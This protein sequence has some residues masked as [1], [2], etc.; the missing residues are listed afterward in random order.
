V[1]LWRTL[2]SHGFSDLPPLRLDE[3]ARTLELTVPMP[4]GRP[5]RVR[6]GGGRRGRAAVEV[7]GGGALSAA[8]RAAVTAA[9]TH[10]L[11]LDQDLSGFYAM[12]DQ[13]PDL[14]WVTAGAGRML[15]SP[16]VFE[17]VVKTICTT[18]CTWALTTVM[19]TALVTQLGEPAAGHAR[20]PRSNAF[21]SPAAMAA[22][23]ECVYRDTIRAGYRAPN[24]LRLATMVA[25]GDVDLEPLASAPRDAL[26]DDE[27]EAMLLGLPGVGPYAA[28]HI[29]MTL[30]RNSRLILDSWTRPTY[31]RLAGRRTVPADAAIARR[32]R[33]YGPEAGLAFWLFVTRDWVAD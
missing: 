11:H 3:T 12:A 23:D 4:R 15:R 33:R 32:F 17:D 31:A 21:P 7:L 20:D 25:A 10:V 24:L 5:R 14:A 27:V 16:T 22:V 8:S 18:N 2:T 1:D 19:V 26:P 13:D 29:M 28:A 6:I 9:A 30:G